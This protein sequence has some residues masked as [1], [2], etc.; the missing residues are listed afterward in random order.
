[1]VK[2]VLKVKKELVVPFQ[3]SSLASS[4][5]S[6]A[7]ASSSECRQLPERVCAAQSSCKLKKKQLGNRQHFISK[8]FWIAQVLPDR[9]LRSI[10]A[11]FGPRLTPYLYFHLPMSSEK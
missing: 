7:G 1:M 5:N 4:R 10:A 11:I 6:L 2:M 3:V 8:N 9:I